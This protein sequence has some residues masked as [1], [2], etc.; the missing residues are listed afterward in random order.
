MPTFGGKNSYVSWRETATNSM[1]IYAKGSKRYFSASTILRNKII[2][3][4]N[5]ILTNHGTVLNFDA[6][7]SR[8]DFAYA[9]KRLLHIIEQ[10]LSVMRQ[11]I[12]SIMTYYNEVNKK[13]TDL[14][15]KTI[16]THGTNSDITKE[17]NNKNRQ[18]ALR[19]FMTELNPPLTDILFSISLNNV[20]GALAKAQKLEENK[21][22]ANFALYFNKP[23][24]AHFNKTNNALRFPN[25]SYRDP[26]PNEN[27]N[28]QYQTKPE[29]MESGSSTY[30]V[31]RPTPNFSQGK[32]Q[33]GNNNTNIRD[34]LTNSNMA[35][36]DNLITVLR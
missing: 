35:S 27:Y 28:R 4:A 6:I 36:N 11:G 15:N 10:E 30:A 3:E 23:Q 13:L 20:P 1:K 24:I 19:V 22:R 25:R 12:Q 18:Y 2:N 14:T 21:L 32:F 17:L 5:D 16:M 33:S 8:L 26:R 31:A 34:N 7:I 29:P 9:D